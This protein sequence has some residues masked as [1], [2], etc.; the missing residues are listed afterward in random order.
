MRE[1]CLCAFQGIRVV[2]WLYLGCLT[3]SP[4]HST[5]EKSSAE[6]CA[7]LRTSCTAN[8]GLQKRQQ[9]GQR[10]VAELLHLLRLFHITTNSYQT[11]FCGI[12]QLTACSYVLPMFPSSAKAN[13]KWLYSLQ[14][15]LNSSFT[16]AQITSM[17][18]ASIL[19]RRKRSELLLFVWTIRLRRH[20]E[21]SW[22][23]NATA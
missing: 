19:T 20:F 7:R 10:L 21:L 6:S 22:A 11:V 17:L 18:I 14:D 23:L 8:R 3:V 2:L 16:T 1:Q 15:I 9:V 13:L 12:Y 4:G 5:G